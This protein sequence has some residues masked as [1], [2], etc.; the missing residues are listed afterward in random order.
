MFV[1]AY[2]PGSGV[3]SFGLVY[4]FIGFAILVSEFLKEIRS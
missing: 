2:D 4:N 3:I 1:P